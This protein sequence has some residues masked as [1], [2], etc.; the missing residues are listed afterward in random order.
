MTISQIRNFLALAKYQN[1]SR[2][3]GALFISEQALS[4]S[5]AKFE[6]ELGLLLFIRKY[7]QLTIT[8]EGMALYDYLARASADYEKLIASLQPNSEPVMQVL[9]IGYAPLLD[10]SQFMSEQIRSLKLDNAM[11]MLVVERIETSQVTEMLLSNKLDLCFCYP[12][13]EQ[14]PSI[15]GFAVKRC[16]IFL[17]ISKTNPHYRENSGLEDYLDEPIYEAAG[18]QKLGLHT[19]SGVYRH[20]LEDIMERD[21]IT[22]HKINVRQVPTLESVITAVESGMG[23]AV[24]P[25]SNPL[26]QNQRIQTYSLGMDSQVFCVYSKQNR[27]PFTNAFVAHLQSRHGLQREA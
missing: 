21:H 17:C 7:H 24:F 26:T 2:A 1:F 4:K 18:Y 19:R 20:I 10:M 22:G 15:E 5:I 6:A 23:V 13:Y 9:N 25:G 14:N 16:G 12:D 27:E 11:P 8:D 3:A